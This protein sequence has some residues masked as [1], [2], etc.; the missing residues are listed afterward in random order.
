MQKVVSFLRGINVSG[1]KLIAM[2]DLRALYGDLGFT[3]VES[4]IQS[5][6]VVFESEEADSQAIAQMISDKITEAYNFTVPVIVRTAEEIRDVIEDNPF[7]R[8]MYI[9]ED[10]LHVTFLAEAPKPELAEK[11]HDQ[12]FQ[13]ERFAVHHKEVYLY[14]PNGYGNTKLNNNFFESKLKVSATT[15]NW[16]TV[17]KLAEMLGVTAE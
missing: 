1:K 14:C 9:E 15:R 13:P 10:R 5:G 12:K 3:N 8:E 2:E 7:L 4:Y 11:M 17:N 6:N 16:K